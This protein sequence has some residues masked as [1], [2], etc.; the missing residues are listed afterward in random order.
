MVGPSIGVPGSS[1][2][3][4]LIVRDVMTYLFSLLLQ[5]PAQT[6][7]SSNCIT[8]AEKGGPSGQDLHISVTMPSIEIGTVGGGTVLPAQSSCLKVERENAPLYACIQYMLMH[9]YRTWLFC[10]CVYQSCYHVW[11]S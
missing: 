5:D 11:V 10:V 3:M 6:V 7:G 9:V 4:A 1:S 2:A 8:L